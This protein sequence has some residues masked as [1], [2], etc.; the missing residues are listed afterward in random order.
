MGPTAHAHRALPAQAR[1]PVARASSQFISGLMKV[2]AQLISP[3]SPLMTGTRAITGA[4]LAIP[5]RQ[6]VAGVEIVGH[7]GPAGLAARCSQARPGVEAD[8]R[9]RSGLVASPASRRAPGQP[10]PVP[11]RT[12]LTISSRTETTR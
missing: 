11:S 7:R 2:S 1:Q 10:L 5:A 12:A 4:T 6:G 3:I 8:R 9:A